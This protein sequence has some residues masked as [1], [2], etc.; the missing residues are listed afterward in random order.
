MKSSNRGCCTDRYLR[1]NGVDNKRIFAI[2]FNGKGLCSWITVKCPFWMFRSQ[3]QREWNIS[4]PLDSI[5]RST[6]ENTRNFIDCKDIVRLTWI[7]EYDKDDQE[8]SRKNIYQQWLD[9]FK[10]DGFYD[11]LQLN[12]RG[13][14]NPRLSRINCPNSDAPKKAETVRSAVKVMTTVVF[15]AHGV[16]VIDFLERKEENATGESY[17]AL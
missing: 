5:K 7:F 12:N 15:Y 3:H 9:L 14:I 16:N 13:L 4:N 11:P 6:V 17:A 2:V 10:R 8:R 1:R